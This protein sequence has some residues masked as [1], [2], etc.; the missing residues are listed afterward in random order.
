MLDQPKSCGMEGV[1][2]VG[3]WQVTHLSGQGW[4]QGTGRW[5]G[6]VVRGLGVVSPALLISRITHTSES[7]TC[8]RTTYVVDVL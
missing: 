8:P 2:G 6:Q 1:G 5:L 7:I 3:V 4:G